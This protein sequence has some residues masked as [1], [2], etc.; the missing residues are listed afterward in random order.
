MK[1]IEIDPASL[2]SRDVSHLMNG[3]VVPRPIAWVSTTDVRGNRNL[4]PHSYF[5]AVSCEPPIVQFTSTHSSPHDAAGHKDTLRNVGATGE[6]V[7]NIV[8]EELL[9]A[10]NATAIDSP[11]GVDEFRIAGL[12]ATPSARVRPPRVTRCKIS[13]ECR[14]RMLLPIGDATMVFGDVLLVHVRDDVWADGR[15]RYDEL[16][17]VGRLGGSNYAPFRGLLT[18]R[19]PRW[20]DRDAAVIQQEDGNGTVSAPGIG[21]I[22]HD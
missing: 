18:L 5:N 13:L 22:P 12:E 21:S 2:A 11:P 19:R 3:I 16:K 20:S 15:V 7:V 9:A 14:V 1:F 10:M 8:S 6:F 17:A 4:A